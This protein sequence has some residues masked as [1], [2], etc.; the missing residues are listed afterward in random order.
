MVSLV[1]RVRGLLGSDAIVDPG[2][3]LSQIPFV[4]LDTELTGLDAR[5][6][7][8]VSVGAVKMAGT[9]IE[10]GRTYYR[11]VRPRSDFNHESIVV[12]GITPDDVAEKPP[13]DTV[14]AELLAFC[15]DR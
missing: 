1:D 5:R 15:G 10:L 14:A 7:S 6:D 9:R 2:L 12:H 8:V 13:I 11:L 4:V 3:P